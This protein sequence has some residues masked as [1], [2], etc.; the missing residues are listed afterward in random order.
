MS[1]HLEPSFCNGDDVNFS[2]VRTRVVHWK[3]SG[4]AM[5]ACNDGVGVSESDEAAQ[6]I[7]VV[8]TWETAHVLW[9]C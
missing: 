9:Q 2:I 4:E 8:T 7:P 3:F 1:D 6:G 5:G